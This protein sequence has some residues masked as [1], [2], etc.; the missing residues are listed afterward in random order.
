MG[1]PNDDVVLIEKGKKPGETCVITIN[2]PDKTGLGCDLCRIILEFGLYITKGDVSTD[3]RWCYIV[4]WV[5][6][7]STMTDERWA[8]LEERLLSVCPSC[9][10]SFYYIQQSS[11]ST[12]TP[13]YLLKFC[14][15]DHKGLLHDV[16][17][18]LF[19]LELTIQRVK[20]MTTPDDKVMDLFFITDTLELLHTK[21]RRNETCE[22]LDAVLGDSCISCELQLAGPEYEALQNGASALSAAES[23]ELFSCELSEKETHTQ[24]LSPDLIKLKQATVKI[25]N[26]LSPGHTLFQIR[27]V[28]Q[29]GLLYDI[30]RTSKDCDVQVL[31]YWVG[32]GML[33]IF[34]GV[35]T[36]AFPDVTGR[37][38][39]LVDLHD[40]SSYLLL[41][42]GATYVISGL[43][44]IGSLKRSRQ[45]KETTREQAVKDL[46][47]SIL[48]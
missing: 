21:K 41:A 11:C 14:C 12:P 4:L 1:L 32:R 29:K 16:T 17:H 25:D 43:L 20:V 6:P 45:Q 40:I 24:V 15:L 8:S 18:V 47:V 5:I 2:C 23:E 13:V 36:R 34:V 44:C 27:C 46:E 35:M 30:M 38:K 28:D 19:D 22:R 3:G 31:E 26:S 42:C 9:L 33:Q 37:R 10:A 48:G 7:D 39:E